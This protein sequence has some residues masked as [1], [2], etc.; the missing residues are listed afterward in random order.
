MKGMEYEKPSD[1]DEFKFMAFARFFIGEIKKGND[2][3][4][5]GPKHDS[6]KNIYDIVQFKFNNL[7]YFMGQFLI[8]D[9]LIPT[10]NIFSIDNLN[11]NIFKIGTIS[12][13]FDCPSIIPLNINKNSNIKV[14]ITTE[15]IKELPLLIEGL[16]KLNRSDPAVEYYLQSNGEHILVTS[17]EVI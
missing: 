15:N 14:S 2:Y 8:I 6:K 5:I 17:G 1:G 11:K 9:N 4:V 13:S 16:K 12:S 10:G 7:Y 3:Y